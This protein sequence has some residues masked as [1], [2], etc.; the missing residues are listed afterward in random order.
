[1]LMLTEK[2]EFV[3]ED[4]DNDDPLLQKI[5]K[6]Q[7]SSMSLCM[8][9]PLHSMTHVHVFVKIF[10]SSNCMFVDNSFSLYMMKPKVVIH[11]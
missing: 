1:M 6:F 5:R 11:Y 10:Y 3:D 4:D 8:N 7:L 2:H 9:L